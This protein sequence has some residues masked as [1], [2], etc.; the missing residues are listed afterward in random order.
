RDDLADLRRTS[1]GALAEAHGAHL[2]QRADRFREAFSNRQHAGNG[3]GAD[4]AEANEQH[5][6]PAA[7]RRDIYGCRHEAK[8]ISAIVQLNVDRSNSI[9]ARSLSTVSG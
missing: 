9:A 8:T 3:R 2:R 4:G 7:R 6:Q 5:A 1:F